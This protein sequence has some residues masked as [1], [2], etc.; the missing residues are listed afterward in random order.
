VRV[1]AEPADQQQIEIISPAQRCPRRIL[2]SGGVD[3]AV[4]RPDADRDALRRAV[5]APTPD[6]L[7]LDVRITEGRQ[8]LEQ[9]PLGLAPV[10]H[11]HGEQVLVH[12]AQIRLLG[13]LPHQ[14]PSGNLSMNRQQLE[15]VL[16]AAARITGDPDIL[17]IGSRSI[18]GQ[19]LKIGYRA[20]P[21]RRFQARCR[22]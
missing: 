8:R 9:Q 10:L 18:P 11:P 1:E 13:M 19:S 5:A 21:L 16:R 20:R 14:L 17:V 4:L 6:A 22:A 3:R 12:T 7:E 2:D 15:H